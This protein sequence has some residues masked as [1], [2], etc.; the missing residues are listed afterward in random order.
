[1]TAGTRTPTAARNGRDEI[2]LGVVG[3]GQIGRM[4]AALIAR[5]LPGARLAAVCD[6]DPSLAERVAR[7]LGAE[8]AGSA[9]ELIAGEVDAVLICSST[10]THRQLIEAVVAARLPVL[11][12][13]PLTL[14]LP[15]ARRLRRLGRESGTII[16]VGFNRRFDPAHARVRAVVSDGSLGDVHMVRISSRD[17]APPP[18]AYA[19]VSGGLFLDM[20]SHD[21]DMA[22]FISGSEVDEVFA[23]GATRVDPEA[24]P[25][26]DVDTAVAVLSHRDGCMTTI[27]NSRGARYGYDQRVEAFGS[28]A[29]ASSGNEL[30]STAVLY[31]PDGVHAAPLRPF[32]LER[33]EVSYLRELEAFVDAVAAGAPAPVTARDAEAALAIGLAARTSLHE[34]RPVAVEEAYDMM[35]AGA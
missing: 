33:Y 34:G 10:D 28:R 19:R 21:F 4:H 11:C 23:R 32:Y 20:A 9:S 7:E 14:S 27:D 6:A 31:G 18:L 3:T 8:V 24:L 1:M 2:A 26:D 13:K 16:Q 17:P 12:E 15:E 35:G 25:A 5:R 30:E 29:M 22:R